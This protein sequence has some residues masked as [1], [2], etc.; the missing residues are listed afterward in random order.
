VKLAVQPV[1][2]AM[3]ELARLAQVEDDLQR[4]ARQVGYDALAA[5]QELTAAKEALVQLERHAGAAGP[6]GPTAKD[7]AAAEKRLADAQEAAGAPWVERR[8]GAEAAARDARHAVVRHAAEHLG[9]L[10]A[11]V[12]EVGAAAAEQVNA[13]GEAFLAAVARRREIETS[14]VEVV[15]LTRTNSPGDFNRP[16]SD[17]ARLAVSQLLQQGG[18]VGPALRDR[19]LV[20]AA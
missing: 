15:A 12:E 4:K 18:E 11:E 10:V 5:Q 17:A 3:V 14:L 9:E 13:C 2:E 16:R 1:G 20:P 7:R 6:D 8:Q 19:E